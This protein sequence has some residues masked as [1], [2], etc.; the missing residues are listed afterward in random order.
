[1][2]ASRDDGAAGLMELKRV[3]EHLMPGCDLAPG[4]ARSYEHP[5]RVAE[6][7]W[8]GKATGRL[9]ELHPSLV[10]TGRAAVLDLDLALVQSLAAAGQVSYTPI[11]RHP[12]SA[13]DLSVVTG[14]GEL[15]GDIGKKLKGYAAGDLV[16]I[17]FQRQY[18]GPPLSEGSK[19]VSF[20]LT[21]GAD[22]TLSNEEVSVIRARIIAAMRGE[23]YELR[24]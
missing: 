10:E 6:V 16:S 15:V 11:R 22:R 20:R 1:V 21:V 17:E 12:A 24:V 2:V 14:L 23:G 8:R 9:F 3:A 19:S 13:F 5:A 18:T 7:Y 4:E